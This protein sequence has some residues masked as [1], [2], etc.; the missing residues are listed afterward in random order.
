MARIITIANQKGGVGKSTT[1]ACM[2]A[3]LIHLGQTALCVDADPQGNLSHAFGAD[4]SC[5]GLY[6]GLTK[7]V[8]AAD[9]IQTTP[10]GDIIPSTNQNLV[11]V[12]NEFRGQITLL[13]ELL[14]PIGQNYQYLV[15]DTPPSLGILMINAL[16]AS[17]DIIIPTNAD[18]FSMQGLNQLY[19]SIDMLKKHKPYLRVSGVIL[20]RYNAYTTFSRH[21]RQALENRTDTYV[22]KTSIRESITV[23]EAQAK[24]QSLFAY[25]PR[26]GVSKDYLNFI[27]E[28]LSNA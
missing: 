2:T 24:R 14:H 10:Q 7:E 13:E 11:G 20:T 15:I 21:A 6:E 25:A 22:Y 27:K 26:A 23:R 28:Y 9:L 8:T 16:F 12:D 17:N 3:G 19:H 1:A 18:V 5:K 4:V